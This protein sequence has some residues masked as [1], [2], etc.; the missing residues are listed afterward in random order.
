MFRQPFKYHDELTK[1]KMINIFSEYIDPADHEEFIN[2][3]TK[4]KVFNPEK[5]ESSVYLESYRKDLKTPKSEKLK[6]GYVYKEEVSA[7]KKAK[8]K[9]KKKSKKSC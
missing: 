1:S 9:Q 6:E 7:T 3:Q 5:P 2:E 4:G 8:F